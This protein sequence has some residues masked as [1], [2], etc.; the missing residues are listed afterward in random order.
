MAG[1]EL[2]APATMKAIAHHANMAT[3]TVYRYFPSKAE[4]FA[5]VFRVVSAREV[6]A[7]TAA[8]QRAQPAIKSLEAAIRTFVDRAERP[9]AAIEGDQRV[10]AFALLP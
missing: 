7:V 10:E 6:Q 9:I 2:T 4:L 1:M 8:A 3:G 5:E